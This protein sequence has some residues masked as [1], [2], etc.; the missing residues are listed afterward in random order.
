MASYIFIIC[1]EILAIKLRTDKDIK[2]FQLENLSHLLEM[3]ADD[4]SIFLEGFD[5]NLRK[6]L[7]ILGF[8]YR[9]SGLKISISK[10]KA[11][12]FGSGH[13]NTHRLCPDLTQDWDTKFRL[14]GMNFTNNLEGMESNFEIKLEEIRKLYNCWENSCN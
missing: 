12:W 11:I 10:T 14:L 8:F 9:I 13:A 4:C 7:D 5:D 6:T 3:Y 2:G 1:I